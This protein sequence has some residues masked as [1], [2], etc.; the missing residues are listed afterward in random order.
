[1]SYNTISV[2]III[3]ASKQTAANNYFQKHGYGPNNFQKE[4][5][6]ISDPDNQPARGYIAAFQ[7]DTGLLA[8]LEKIRE[9]DIS[10]VKI[11]IGINARK[12]AKV[13]LTENDFRLKP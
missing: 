11:I 13:I 2:V 9:M 6:G 1:M 3:P 7:A 8:L 10:N 5:I 4:I 12:R